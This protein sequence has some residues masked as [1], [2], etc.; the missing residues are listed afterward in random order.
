[1][2]FRPQFPIRVP[3]DPDYEWHPIILSFDPT[4]TP[5]LS[6]SLATGQQTGD[7]PLLP[8]DRQDFWLN[9][10]KAYAPGLKLLLKDADD[11]P[12]MDDFTSPAL[13]I[14]DILVTALEAPLTFF[15][16]GSYLT[17]QLQGE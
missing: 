4:N 6:V 3:D 12:L 9:G 14:G 8:L 16:R 17:V 5:A 1:M 11:N 13:V 10:V 2:A 7:I 15:P